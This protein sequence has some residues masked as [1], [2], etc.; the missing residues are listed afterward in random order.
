M[1][2]CADVSSQI[3]SQLAA[4]LWNKVQNFGKTCY[5]GWPVEIAYGNRENCDRIWCDGRFLHEPHG[6][7]ANYSISH[8]EWVQQ[9]SSSLEGLG[10]NTTWVAT[11][12]PC[13]SGAIL[14]Q[15]AFFNGCITWGIRVVVPYELRNQILHEL[16]E[17]HIVIVEMKGLAWSYVLWPG[18]DQDIE[19][20]AKKCQ[21]C[22]KSSLRLQRCH[23]IHGSG[24]SNHDSAYMNS[25]PGPSSVMFLIVVD[26]HSKWPDVLLTWST[27]SERTVEPLREVFAR[28]GLPEHLNSDNGRQF[29]SEVFQ[30]FMEANNIKHTFSAPYHPATNGQAERFV[31]TFKQA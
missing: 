28:Y 19:S 3:I 12:Q 6:C 31:Q 30:N 27:Y 29:T 4:R 17:G 24:Q 11:I 21:G 18:I 8:L 22:Q 5:C 7:V 2:S 1:V 23:F 14:L 15:T 13:R 25:M 16:H 9:G 20:L 26:S 10:N